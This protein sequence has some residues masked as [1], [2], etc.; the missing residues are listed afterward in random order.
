MIEARSGRLFDFSDQSDA[1]SIGN[2][3]RR[4]GQNAERFYL[5]LI[6]DARSIPRNELIEL[7]HYLLPL[8]CN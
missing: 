3:M 7:P 8:H 6:A 5:E 4:I 1:H 2:E